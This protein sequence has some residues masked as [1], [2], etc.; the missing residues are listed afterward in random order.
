MKKIKKISSSATLDIT[1]D[2]PSSAIKA[3]AILLK[4]IELNNW[5]VIK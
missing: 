1:R 2:R 4:N 3:A 5:F